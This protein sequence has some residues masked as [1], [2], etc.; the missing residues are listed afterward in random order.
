MAPRSRRRVAWRKGSD[1]DQELWPP[2]AFDGVTDEQFW[3]DLAADKPLTT[4]AR[5]AHP[6]SGSRRRPQ[7]G[8][9][10]PEG[11]ADLPEGRASVVDGLVEG[12]VVYPHSQPTAADRVA[13]QPIRAAIQPSPTAA[14]AYQTATEPS[15]T[16]THPVS[17]AHQPAESHR[18]PRTGS[19]GFAGSDEDPLTSPAYSLRPKGAVDGRSYKSSRRS[20]NLTWEQYEAALLQGT[21]TFSLS[22]AQG[23]TGGSPDSM[24]PFRQPELSAHGR[25]RVSEVRSDPLRSD[26]LRS[27]GSWPGS[28]SSPATIATPVYQ[29]SL[30]SV[31]AYIGTGGYSSLEQLY[32]QS[33][34]A[35]KTPP[36]G[37]M[38]GYGNPAGLAGNPRPP[39]GARGRGRHVGHSFGDGNWGSRPAYPPAH[40]YRAPYD[41]WGNDRRLGSL[42]L[43]RAH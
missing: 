25:G 32:G 29:S 12:S 24:P 39:D 18:R 41:P 37:E 31:G 22:D 14:R 21:Q 17:I 43:P 4:T 11:R 5:T 13:M 42:R 40:G 3:D 38:Y 1:V 15:P 20:R 30:R 2:E 36:Y 8:M 23:A 9:P 16:A 35:M 19:S 26:P 33:I 28:S 6:D 27:D 10:L 7:T 34:Q